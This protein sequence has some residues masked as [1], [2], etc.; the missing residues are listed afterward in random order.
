[1]A[2]GLSL[3]LVTRVRQYAR[4]R[5]DLST[6]QAIGDLL[7]YALRGKEAR[8]AGGRARMASLTPEARSALA[9]HAVT[10]RD[11]D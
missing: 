6:S 2:R 9:S 1:M 3:E 8:A 5:P 7:D 11:Q 10:V 4:T